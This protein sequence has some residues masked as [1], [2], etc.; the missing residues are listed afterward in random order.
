[1]TDER[2]CCNNVNYS[3]YFLFQKWTRQHET[4]ARIS[5]IRPIHQLGQ[6]RFDTV[7]SWFTPLKSY[8]VLQQSNSEQRKRL[9]PLGPLTVYRLSACNTSN[10]RNDINYGTFNH[11]KTK[12]RPLYLKTQSVTASKYFSSRL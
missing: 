10:N 6:V 7:C 8:S 1:M 9:C 5:A 11:L 3:L 4:I 12:L 2:H